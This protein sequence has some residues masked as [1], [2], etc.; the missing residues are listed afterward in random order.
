MTAIE[1]RLVAFYSQLEDG[2]TAFT[3]VPE[4]RPA[5]FITIERTGGATD[6]F[7]DSPQ[8]AVQA[9]A[10]TRA[11]AQNLA[12]TARLAAQE[13]RLEPWCAFVNLGGLYD[14]PD[15]ESKHARYQFTLEIGVMNYQ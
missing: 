12:Y 14:F 9:W 4:K 10:G 11:Q 2:V 1:A 8:I 13:L 5:R 6:R 7:I 3:S 15:P